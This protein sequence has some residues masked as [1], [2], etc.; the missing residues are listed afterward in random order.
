MQAA[1]FILWWWRNSFLRRS[2]PVPCW[3]PIHPLRHGTI[4][5]GDSTGAFGG[6][7]KIGT[8][9]KPYPYR[10]GGRWGQNQPVEFHFFLLGNPGIVIQPLKWNCK[11]TFLNKP[12]ALEQ[13]WWRQRNFWRDAIPTHVL[14][15]SDMCLA[16]P[17]LSA[18]NNLIIF[19]CL[20]MTWNDE[21]YWSLRKHD[22]KHGILK[23]NFSTTSPPSNS[24]FQRVGPGWF[25]CCQAWYVN[26]SNC[27]CF[28]YQSLWIKY[29]VYL[30]TFA[31]NLAVW[32]PYELFDVRSQK[33]A[34]FAG[35]IIL[36]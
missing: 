32:R 17:E 30:L 26:I 4:P 1:S 36:P 25:S 21:E 28:Q 14:L 3:R 5:W 13:V 18:I 35:T 16:P 29:W 34:T 8:V 23:W 15:Q 27:P 10:G 12:W 20:P 19:I 24:I 2:L 7:K 22:C 6:K 11:V 9:F 31:V 33:L